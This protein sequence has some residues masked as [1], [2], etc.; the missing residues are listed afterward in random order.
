MLMLEDCNPRETALDW[1]QAG[2]PGPGAT[3]TTIK[4]TAQ[5]VDFAS[6]DALF[7]ERLTLGTFTKTVDRASCTSRGRGPA[8]QGDYRWDVHVRAPRR[9]SGRRRLHRRWLRA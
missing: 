6:T 5:D 2:P 8:Y 1:N 7:H 3:V 4:T 9:W